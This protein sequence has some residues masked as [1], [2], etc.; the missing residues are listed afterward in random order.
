MGS[1]PQHAPA[2]QASGPVA[3]AIAGTQEVAVPVVFSVLTTVAAFVPLFYIS[4]TMGKFIS[5]IPVVLISILLVSLAISLFSLPALLAWAGRG[6]PPA[7]TDQAPGNG[8][9]SGGHLPGQGRGQDQ[10]QGAA[11]DKPANTDRANGRQRL[12]N[13]LLDRLIAGPY[14]R[15]L[16]FCLTWRGLT[17]ALALVMLMLAVGAV[18]GGLLPFRFMPDLEGDIIRVELEMPQGTLV[19][20]TAAI[21]EMITARGQQVVSTIDAERRAPGSVLRHIH[22]V[23]GATVERGGPG[24]GGGNDGGNLASIT[25]ML[26]PVEQRRVTAGQV[27]ARWRQAV[28]EIPGVKSLTF[29]TNLVHFGDQIDIQLSHED[30]DTLLAAR[31]RLKEVLADYP[32]VSDIADTF[33]EGKRELRLKLRPQ[34]R[35]L[36]LQAED[37]GRQVRAAFFGAEALRL[38]RGRNEVKVMVRYPEGRRDSV[39]DL[40]NLR[41]RTADGHEIPLPAAAEIIEGQSHAEINRH[42]RKRVVNITASVDESQSNAS[43]ILAALE[44]GT[45]A[46][47]TT[48]YPGLSYNLEGEARERRESMASMRQGFILA[49][50]AIYALLAVPLRSFSQPLIIMVAIP[51]GVVGALLGHWLLGY[52]LSM[53]SL[54]GIIALSGVVV[55]NSL[56]LID[57]VNRNRASGS[58]APHL[59]ASGPT[60]M[61]D[62]S[63]PSR[64][65]QPTAPGAPWPGA[66]EAGVAT[67]REAVIEAG[68]RRFRPIMLTSL[69]TFFGLF[70]MILETSVQAQFL[71]PMAISLGFGVLFSTL[72]TLVLVPTLYLALADLKGET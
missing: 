61:A 33:P 12:A 27:A 69:T 2:D 51:F 49:L 70:P 47:L 14:R 44:A 5:N 25:M 19:T 34:A 66:N 32:G 35:S 13:R 28:G 10:G 15:S 18:G 3:A 67:V 37:L 1:H 4:G 46:E 65:P 55:N 42:D 9:A 53:M 26:Q 8:Q 17:I 64:L 50:L 40:E 7:A 16:D 59:A 43:E 39:R 11:T 63:S 41:L 71:I 60:Q 68:S 56:L 72:I 29:T 22:S 58:R 24:G 20:R 54:F 36:G 30:F 23:V 52:A 62:H 38:Q 45:L 57:R 6:G 48:G 31:A 21:E